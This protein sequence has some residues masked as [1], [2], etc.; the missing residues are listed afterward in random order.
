M[1]EE[2]EGGREAPDLH[3]VRAAALFGVKYEAVTPEQ[4]AAAKIRNYVEAYGIS[5]WGVGPFG[6]EEKK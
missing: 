5:T 4:R 3:R 2:K 1:T 6:K